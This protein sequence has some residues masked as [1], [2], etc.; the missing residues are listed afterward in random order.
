MQIC[1]AGVLLVY[2]LFTLSW[3]QF[4]SGSLRNGGM[5][6]LCIYFAVDGMPIEMYGE[7]WIAGSLTSD[8]VM[9]YMA[10]FETTRNL[11]VLTAHSWHELHVY[12]SY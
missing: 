7:S 1:N 5:L 12:G 4:E 11:T 6:I 3:P 8:D 10:G 9:L 2:S